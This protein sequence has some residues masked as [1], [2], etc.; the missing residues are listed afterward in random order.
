M[1]D[2]L[3]ITDKEAEH[4]IWIH[5]NK[6]IT[7]DLFFKKFL[8]HQSSRNAYY[9]LNK[10][11]DPEKG[12]LDVEQSS[13]TTSSYFFLTAKAL[14]SLDEQNRI[15]VRSSRYPVR[16]NLNEKEHDLKVQEVRVAIEAS[17]DLKDVFWVTDF[18]LRS[19]IT[20]AIKAAF[21]EGRL[22]KQDWRLNGFNPNPKGRRT[23]D[24]YFEADLEGEREA[25]TLEFENQAYNDQKVNRMTGYLKDYYPNATKLVISATRKNAERMIRALQKKIKSGEQQQWFV[26]D[27]EKVTTLPF[28]RIWHR[29]DHVLDE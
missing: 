3:D 24:G 20:P 17:E 11:A 27:L 5:S 18:E 29:I 9:I 23:P 21:L 14:K 2:I 1:K 7:P 8:K 19:G 6:F 22:D 4:L 12:F 15:L 25:F 13:I 16:V 28:K 26:S 10:Y